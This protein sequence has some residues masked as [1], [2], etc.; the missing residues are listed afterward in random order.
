[1]HGQRQVKREFLKKW[2]KGLQTYSNWSKDMS[3]VE[4]KEAIKLSADV[5]MASTTSC[6]TTCWGR[7]LIANASKNHS[8]KVVVQHM[9]GHDHKQL[10]NIISANKFGI[11]TN[12]SSA[13]CSSTNKR[14]RFKK[15]L[16]K[17]C[18]RR[19]R[20]IMEPQPP[21]VSAT[22]IAEKMVKKRTEM[23]KVLVPG[24]EM[25]DDVCVIREA[26][27][28]INSLRLQVKVMRQLAMTSD[29]LVK[30]CPDKKALS[31]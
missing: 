11:S 28:Y 14:V 20:K 10:I 22:R 23:L 1:M 24:G 31:G 18:T 9:L 25:M 6:A 2:A 12:K 26:H 27:D 16:R 19:L 21:T 15:I 8:T 4:R 13:M 5:A 17:S 29:E 3:L 30:Y 7:A